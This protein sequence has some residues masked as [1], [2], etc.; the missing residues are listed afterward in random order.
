[1]F[2][3]FKEDHSSNLPAGIMSNDLTMLPGG[4]VFDEN[5]IDFH[6]DGGPKYTD[7]LVA[8]AMFNSGDYKGFACPLI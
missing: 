2:N 5:K 6:L 4:A 8:S 3:S 7:V 1:M